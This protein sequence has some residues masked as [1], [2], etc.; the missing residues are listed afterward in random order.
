MTKAIVKTKENLAIFGEK[1]IRR[2]WDEKEG[3]WYFSVIDVIEVLTNQRDHQRAR[4]YWKVLKS[5]LLAEGN[6][7]VTN[8]NRL[9]LLAEDGRYRFTD[10]ANTET[11]LRLIQSIPSP[12]AEP[13]KLWLAQVG[14]ERIAEIE[15]P[16]LAMD[17]MKKL[18]EQKGY[19]KVWIE[20]RE[21]GITTRH[22][23]TDEWR[24]RGAAA[25]D[26]AI[27]TNEI[28]KS[29]FGLTAKE[30]KNVKNLHPSKNLRDSMTNI[31]LALTN[32]GEA[33]A[34]EFHQ[35]N[36]SQGIKKLKKDTQ[37]AGGVLKKAKD[38][39]EK[40]LQRP[41]VTKANFLDLTEPEKTQKIRF[42]E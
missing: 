22:S 23:L 2:V 17:R 38:E 19:P 9:K 34:T 28:Y 32:L 4:N 36:N 1:E 27:L 35:K 30:Y 41:V 31:E 40:E 39:I 24:A 25:R 6:K 8:C 20:Q 11:I 21:R 42:K 3:K 15:N 7:T 37:K 5:R 29:G 10:V 14:S 18:Y 12:K 16:E 13:F 26:Y 33:T